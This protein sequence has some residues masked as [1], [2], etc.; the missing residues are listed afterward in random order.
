MEEIPFSELMEPLN[1]V[2]YTTLL[3]FALCSIIALILSYAF[4]KKVSAPIRSFY[5][6]MKKVQEGNLDVVSDIKG[7]DEITQLSDGFNRM[8]ENIKELLA[9]IK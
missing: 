3:V 5:F 8:V 2:R 9:N 4:A 1:K 6:S 7:W